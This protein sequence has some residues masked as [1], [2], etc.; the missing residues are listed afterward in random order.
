MANGKRIWICLLNEDETLDSVLGLG[1][2]IKQKKKKPLPNTS[3]NNIMIYYT[4]K[5]RKGNIIQN[6]GPKNVI[7]NI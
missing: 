6:H 2:K 4:K 3:T 1:E 7:F 5:R